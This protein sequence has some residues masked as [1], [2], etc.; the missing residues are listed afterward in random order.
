MKVTADDYYQM[1][2]TAVLQILRDVLVGL[3]ENYEEGEFQ[4]GGIDAVLEV[5]TR[6]KRH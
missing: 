4:Q 2:R 6:V 1:E 3:Q 5:W